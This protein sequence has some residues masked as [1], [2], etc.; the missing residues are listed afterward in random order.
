MKIERNE[1]T[2]RNLDV[3]PALSTMEELMQIRKYANKATPLTLAINLIREGL[4]STF[5]D[6][7]KLL[8]QRHSKINF[9]AIPYGDL[10]TGCEVAY[11][12]G[13]PARR[14]KYAL[15]IILD[16]DLATAECLGELN[17]TPQEN[18]ERLKYTGVLKKPLARIPAN[19]R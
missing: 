5:A 17:I 16:G 18:L 12:Y 13:D 4:I 3:E 11:P 19:N 6:F 9:I 15:K 1:Q 14:P 2:I 10:P 8:T 7:Q